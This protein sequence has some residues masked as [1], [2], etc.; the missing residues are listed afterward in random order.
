MLV[1]LGE[2]NVCCLH[3]RLALALCIY[4]WHLVFYVVAAVSECVSGFSVISVEMENVTCSTCGNGE[5]CENMLVCDGCDDVCHV[6]CLIL[7]LA[8]NQRNEWRCPKC[9]AKVTTF[10]L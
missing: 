2:E 6:Y 7:P 3:S 10:L 4:S 9:I 8:D 5:N 1:Y